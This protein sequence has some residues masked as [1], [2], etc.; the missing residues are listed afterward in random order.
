MHQILFGNILLL[1]TKRMLRKAQPR[2]LC[3]C[4][5]TKCSTSRANIKYRK[6]SC[7]GPTHSRNAPNKNDDDRHSAFKNAQKTMGGILSEGKKRKQQVK[8]LLKS[9]TKQAV[10]SS[11]TVLKSGSRAT[12]AS[13]FYEN[14]IS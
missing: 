8:E 13:F 7:P 1:Q 14:G 3:A 4:F 5:V 6:A 12:I 2:M 9:P 11:A 10:E